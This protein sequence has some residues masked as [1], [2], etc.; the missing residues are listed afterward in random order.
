MALSKHFLSN[1]VSQLNISRTQIKLALVLGVLSAFALYS[2]FNVARDVFRFMSF[3]VESGIWRLSNKE[4]FYYN[5]FYAYVSSIFGQTIAI[6]FLL[7]KSKP[8]FSKRKFRTLDIFNH[9]QFYTWNTLY[10]LTRIT[11]CYGILFYAE[12]NIFITTPDYRYFFILLVLV[13]FFSSW[14][15][16][17]LIFRRQALKILLISA[18]VISVLSLGLSQIN[19]A[20]LTDLEKQ[21][22]KLN[23]HYSYQYLKVESEYY[24]Y[25]GKRDLVES[26]Y[27]VFPKDGNRK[28]PVIVHQNKEYQ[29]SQIVNLITTCRTNRDEADAKYFSIQLCVHKDISIDFVNKVKFE[30]AN[31]GVYK[32]S[33]SVNPENAEFGQ[34]YYSNYGIRLKLP[35]T[36]QGKFGPPLPKSPYIHFSQPDFYDKCRIIH[37]ISDKVFEVNG[38]RL[39]NKELKGYFKNE[40][41][42]NHKVIFVNIINKE[43]SFES[44]LKVFESLMMA[45]EEIKNDYS[46]ETYGIPFDDLRY[47]E[48]H[49]IRKK[50]RLPYLE[51]YPEF[52]NFLVDEE[53]ISREVM[54]RYVRKTTGFND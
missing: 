7:H 44:Y 2:L 26:I 9:H 42:L 31:S 23:I 51:L 13:L 18:V 6:S 40:L 1:R 35:P 45:G 41:A 39:Y 47:D 4:I 29:V 53:G 48:A 27:I 46:I 37:Q 43:Q 14:N 22:Q 49:E 8:A 24:N 11:T 54:N 21:I 50:T 30:I 19:I 32:I 16:T 20:K 33:Y 10:W 25:I 34:E 15:T 12:F 3:H 36:R 38:N 52:V 5:L 28:A 17:I